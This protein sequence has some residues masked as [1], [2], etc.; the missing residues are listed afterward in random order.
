MQA[1]HHAAVGNPEIRPMSGTA[2]MWS[3]SCAI[4]IV[5]LVNM[6]CF[7]NLYRSFEWRWI[8]E[9]NLN[10]KSPKSSKHRLYTRKV[11]R[12][13]TIMTTGARWQVETVDSSWNSSYHASGS[14]RDDHICKRS[15]AGRRSGSLYLPISRSY[16]WFFLI[17]WGKPGRLISRYK[18]GYHK[19]AAGLS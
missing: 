1:E 8:F 18:K 14:L 4:Y 12:I 11:Y 15:L 13:L 17:F 9:C 3:D 6:I 19:Q 7:F 2:I 5:K 16:S 10:L